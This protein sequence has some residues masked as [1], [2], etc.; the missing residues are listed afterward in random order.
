MKTA[1]DNVLRRREKSVREVA[2]HPKGT[3][4]SGQENASLAR[5]PGVVRNPLVPEIDSMG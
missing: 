1:R 3:C 4:F 2:P 5:A